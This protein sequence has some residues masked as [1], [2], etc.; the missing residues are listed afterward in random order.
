LKERKNQRRRKTVPEMSSDDERSWTLQDKNKQ[1]CQ[2]DDKK[3]KVMK[4]NLQMMKRI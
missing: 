3:R 1:A 4:T 2:E